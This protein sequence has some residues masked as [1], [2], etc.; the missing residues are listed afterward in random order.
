MTDIYNFYITPEEYKRAAENGI[1][2]KRL[3]TRIRDMAWDKEKAITTPVKNK[4]QYPREIK[5]LAEKNGICMRTFKSR[6][7]LLGWDMLK[8]ATTPV[9]DSRQNIYKAI[10]KVRKYPKE[11]I[12]LAR[13]NGIPDKCF[14]NRITKYKWTIERA[15]TTPVMT[16]QEVGL[17]TKEKRKKV[18]DWIFSNNRSKGGLKHNGRA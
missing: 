18:N 16:P 13:E 15:A 14:Y 9:M 8:A 12:E 7:N 2:K 4:K 10:P 5:E 3:E 1:S 17:M 6:V 11:F